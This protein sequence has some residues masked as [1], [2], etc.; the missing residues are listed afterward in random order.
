MTRKEKIMYKLGKI[1]WALVVACL[2]LLASGLTM[3]GVGQ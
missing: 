3:I 1:D 2:L